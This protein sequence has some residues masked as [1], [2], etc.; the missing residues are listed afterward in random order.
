MIPLHLLSLP[1]PSSPDFPRHTIAEYQ[2]IMEHV[3]CHFAVNLI[4]ALRVL[5]PGILPPLN[6]VRIYMHVLPPGRQ[7][8]WND[9]CCWRH[10]GPIEVR[11]ANVAGSNGI[12]SW[13]RFRPSVYPSLGYVQRQGSEL[14]VIS[15]RRHGWLV[16]PAGALAIVRERSGSFRSAPAYVQGRIRGE[17]PRETSPRWRLGLGCGILQFA[18]RADH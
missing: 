18:W 6:Y 4:W 15:L 12:E 10:L 13:P 2:L 7:D 17:G 8:L 14:I 16:A 3:L 11:R 1:H 9:V 5:C